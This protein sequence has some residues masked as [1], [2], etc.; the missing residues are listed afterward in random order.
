M[1]GLAG[2]EIYS[3]PRGLQDSFLSFPVS[4]MAT[5]IPYI[6]HYF[7]LVVTVIQY[8]RG[9]HEQALLLLWS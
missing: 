4:Q 5:S 7:P 3:D 2:R 9:T 8:S 1:L 6:V